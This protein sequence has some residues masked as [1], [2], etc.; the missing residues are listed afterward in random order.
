[1]SN[2]LGFSSARPGLSTVRA[3]VGFDNV[4]AMGNLY[5]TAFAI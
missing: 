1:M 3:S 2:T 4:P 5:I